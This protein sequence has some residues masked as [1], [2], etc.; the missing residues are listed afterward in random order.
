MNGLLIVV[1]GPSG[2]GKGTI[3]KALMEE[4]KNMELSVSVTTR[5]PREGEVEGLSYY[6]KTR[7][8]F[9]KMKDNDEFLEYAHVYGNYYGTPKKMVEERL[10]KSID[11]MLEIDMQGALQ[12]SQ[13]FKKAILVFIMPP[14]LTELQNRI[15]QRGTETLESLQK[16]M[17]ATCGE[18]E[19]VT[20]Y[21]YCIVNDNVQ[22]AVHKLKAIILAEKQH[23]ANIDTE[24]LIRDIKEGRDVTA[25]N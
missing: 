17:A 19:M 1:S 7:E 10:E 15:R 21:D 24:R 20:N 9:L 22:S 25:I 2:A 3:C 6:F 16:R 23:L 5:V 13:S 8:E 18:V 12:V 11:I 14:S 4:A